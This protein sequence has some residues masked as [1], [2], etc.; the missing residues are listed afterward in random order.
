MQMTT[1]MADLKAAG[2]FSAEDLMSFPW[3]VDENKAD[4]EEV[5][6]MREEL[7]EANRKRAE[8]SISS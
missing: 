8:A 2:I 4:E 7:L 6:K 3:E 5:A 1:G